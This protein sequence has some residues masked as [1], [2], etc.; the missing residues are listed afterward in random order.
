MEDQIKQRFLEAFDFIVAKE[1]TT[2]KAL[3]QQI[4]MSET[5]VSMIRKKTKTDLKAVF[6][7]SLIKNYPFINPLYI[8][9]GEGNLQA[10]PEDIKA[11]L[12]KILSQQETT[13][14]KLIEALI[15][16]R[17]PKGD[18]MKFISKQ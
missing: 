3:S 8:L 14:D 12:E 11:V 5:Y 9:L 4:G 10:I 15:S 1:Q 6:V 17:I 16:I 18:I 13:I 7:A 2:G